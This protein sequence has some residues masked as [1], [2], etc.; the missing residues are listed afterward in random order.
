[1]AQPKKR[2]FVSLKGLE[3]GRITSAGKPVY[4]YNGEEISE[5]SI[6]IEADG[7]TYVIPT[8]IDGKL[9]TEEAAVAKFF[10]KEVEPI[11]VLKENIKERSKKL[12]EG[13][14]VMKKQME[15]FEDG[16]LKDEGGMIDEVSGNDVPSGSTREEVRDDIPAQLSEGEFVF[17]AD[18]VRFIGL[19]KLMTIRQK[20][21]QGLK[22][23]EAMG[24]MGNSDEATMRDDLPFDI[25]DLDMEDELEY[26][27]GGV[28]RAQQGT[29][30]AP[31]IPMGSQPLGTN[32]M[33]NPT[34]MFPQQVASGVSGASRG[35]PYTPNVGKSYG[36]GATPYAPVSYQDFLGTS[37]GGAP[38]T[39]SVRYFN[40]AT[41]Q[42][43]IIPHLVNADGSRGSTLYPVPE[44]FVIQEEAPKEE[45]KTTQVQSAKVAPVESGDGP[46]DGGGG[47]V[48][49][50]GDP[51]SYNNMFSNVQGTNPTSNLDKTLSALGSM[52][53]GMLT[54]MT[55]IPGI[56]S[57]IADAFS[58]TASAPTDVTVGAMVEAFRTTKEELA[59]VDPSVKGAN[60][61]NLSG[62]DRD[63]LNRAM[64]SAA[65][66]V[67][68]LSR[69]DKGNT[70]NTKDMVDKV[71]AL[72]EKYGIKDRVNTKT[73]VN[74]KVS[75]GK[76]VA[77]I[78][79]A[80]DIEVQ[81][82]MNQS[83]ISSD[84][85]DTGYVD[86]TTNMY[87]DEIDQG[88]A[89]NSNNFSGPSNDVNDSV[90]TE[91]GDAGFGFGSEDGFDFNT[92][93]LAGKKK[94]KPK[95]KKMKRGGLASR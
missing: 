77:Q 40:E 81:T 16:G 73:N 13:G 69:D 90:N 22:Q 88:P 1:M 56:V 8:V 30:V 67:N 92:G 82:Q 10:N 83:A 75:I 48:D 32:P 44:G 79:K 42:T 64:T 2:P 63:A 95:P 19:E 58:G 50:S 36:A 38:T 60:V 76:V 47:A 33:G 87:S 20:A 80:K 7:K 45:A 52:Q 93:G 28:I 6:D 65:V 74:R 4:R 21:K 86:P 51:L 17:P 62:Y 43:R 78:E 49:P 18:V 53:R 85:K 24:Q 15:M 61:A 71:N 84:Q 11:K 89:D 46:S 25:N 3:T 27:R 9:Y 54:T 41:G 91:T 14:T 66:A 23:M 59:V 57:G 29:Y 55:G 31:T 68:D 37:A 35:T 5:K 34:Q 26:N 94:K 12:A 39:E 70:L 72:A